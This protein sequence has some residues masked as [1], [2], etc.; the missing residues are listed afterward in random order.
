[1][2]L[3]GES[4]YGAGW[5]TNDGAHVRAICSWRRPRLRVAPALAAQRATAGHPHP[6]GMPM[7]P[8]GSWSTATLPV[9]RRS[10]ATRFGRPS[11]AALPARS[12]ASSRAAS[13]WRRPAAARPRPATAAA[14]A[15]AAATAAAARAAGACL[16]RMMARCCRRARW[17]ISPSFGLPASGRCAAGAVAGRRAWGA[18]RGGAWTGADWGG[19]GRPGGGVWCALLREASAAGLAW[20]PTRRTLGSPAASPRLPAEPR[21]GRLPG[22]HLP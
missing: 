17:L 8:P 12:S 19:Q 14:A 6:P 16:A 20:L 4:P 15:T 7:P 11:P 3:W 22:A 21:A 18:G 2:L 9:T 5:V 13:R 10:R 1:M